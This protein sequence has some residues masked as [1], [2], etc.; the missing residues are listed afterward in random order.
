[1]LER[2][3]NYWKYGQRDARQGAEPTTVPDVFGPEI[4]EAYDQGYRAGSDGMSG[5]ELRV[6]V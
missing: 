3:R 5:P 2:R 1:M 4:Q 6:V